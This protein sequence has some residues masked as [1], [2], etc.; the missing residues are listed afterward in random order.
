[1]FSHLSCTSHYRIKQKDTEQLNNEYS[2]LVEG[3]RNA[4]ENRET[5]TVLTNPVIPNEILEG[6]LLS[7][8]LYLFVCSVLLCTCANACTNTN[9]YV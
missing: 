1:V 6:E 7:V 3:L 2:R 9:T 5:D 4:R 8:V